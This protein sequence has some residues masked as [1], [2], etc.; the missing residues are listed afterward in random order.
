MSKGQYYVYSIFEM[1]L[2]FVI[3]LD[4][5]HITWRMVPSF[6]YDQA[7]SALPGTPLPSYPSWSYFTALRSLK[8]ILNNKW[9]CNKLFFIGLVEKY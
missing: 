2:Y 4:T 6:F 3:C 5:K 8:M 1:E 7:K 9:S